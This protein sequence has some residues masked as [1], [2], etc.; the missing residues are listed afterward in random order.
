MSVSVKQRASFLRQP[1]INIYICDR[2]RYV[3]LNHSLNLFLYPKDVDDCRQ[4][5]YNSFT[6]HKAKEL[7]GRTIYAT[8]GDFC[9]FITKLR[10]Q[11]TFK[12]QLTA[13][14]MDRYT[15]YLC[16]GLKYP[17]KKRKKKVVVINLIPKEDPEIVISRIQASLHPNNKRRAIETF[18]ADPNVRRVAMMELIN[19]N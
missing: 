18:M 5:F 8:L 13:E 14:D 16:T 7:D 9:A 4:K 3:K 11:I 19:E 10:T 6:K 1:T 2:H 12:R 15:R 17:T